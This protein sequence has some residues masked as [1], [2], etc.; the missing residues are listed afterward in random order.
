MRQCVEAGYPKTFE[1]AARVIFTTHALGVNCQ[2]SAKVYKIEGNG[3][4]II[5]NNPK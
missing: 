4:I 2:A 5:N 1:S 3:T